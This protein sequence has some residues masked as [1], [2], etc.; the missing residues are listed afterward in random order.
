MVKILLICSKNKDG[1]HVSR[2]WIFKYS[3]LEFPNSK[4]WRVDEEFWWK[5]Q[6]C[7]FRSIEMKILI[8]WIF[9]V[10][11]MSW[12]PRYVVVHHHWPIEQKSQVQMKPKLI[13]LNKLVMTH[14][15]DSKSRFMRNYTAVSFE[16]S[17]KV[18]EGHWKLAND[19]IL[20]KK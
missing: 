4:S 17:R 15:H 20:N 6:N 3:D 12:R 2:I 7:L 14:N 19:K 13:V 9:E 11:E 16:K 5:Y 18:A 10:L 8:F 1:P